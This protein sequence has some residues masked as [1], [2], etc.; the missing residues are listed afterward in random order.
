MED[1][2]DH[3]ADLVADH[4]P[5]ARA[6]ARR[7]VGSGESWDDLLQVGCVGLVAAARRFDRSRGTPFTAYAQPTIDGE[8][9]RHLRDR[10]STIRVPRREQR[11][12]ANLRAAARDAVQALGREASFGE[13]AATVGVSVGEAQLVIDAAAAPASLAGLDLPS[14]AADEEIEACE[15]RALLGGMLAALDPREREL[16]RL[17]YTEDLPQTEIARRMRMSQSQ[18]SRLLAGALA[19][20]RSSAG[21]DRAA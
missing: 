19:K 17:R 5:L 8:L 18:A 4:L 10:T 6:I 2:L 11:L 1:R 16:V 13:I 20:L 21:L 15:R 7:Y 3:V 12:A 14:S 9:R